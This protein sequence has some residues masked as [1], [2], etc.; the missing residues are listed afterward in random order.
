LVLA[1]DL[2]KTASYHY[3]LPQHL[4]AQHPL[5]KRDKCRLVVIERETQ[6]IT[7]TTFDALPQWLNSGDCLVLNN[8]KVIPARL[9][10]TKE[11]GGTIEVLLLNQLEDAWDWKV[12]CKPA[13]KI[14]LG[15]TLFFGDHL[16]ASVIAAK[17]EGVRYLRFT[18]DQKTFLEAIDLYGQMP[19]PPYIQR[20]E[21]E[22]S[23]K[24]DYQT[25]FAKEPGAAAAPTAGLHF[26]P[27]LLDSLGKQGVEKAFVTLHVGAGTFRPVQAEDITDHIMH[28][29]SYFL[30]Q[31][32]ARI[33]NNVKSRRV[34]VGTTSL[35]TIES[36]AKQKEALLAG[37][38][39]TDLFISPGYEFAYTDA[40][41]TNFHLPSSTL[42]ML[43][44]AFG[45]YDLI[46]EAY[47]QAIVREYRF[48]SY[49]DAMLIL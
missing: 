45:G 46:M 49:G 38:G 7:H 20:K 18:S 21:Q 37:G 35:R 17:E 8:T 14:K 42:M 30:D 6:K 39:S 26:T 1:Q 36:I 19:L 27:E 24:D 32:N 11:T 28:E 23:D 34:C 15:Q 48:F 9:K 10:G 31:D 33:L 44:S 16:K 22:L 25:V 40:L 29:E 2:T 12:F 13:K 4:I 5:Q 3:E 43:V 47:Q 41:L